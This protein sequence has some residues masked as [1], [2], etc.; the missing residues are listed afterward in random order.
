MRTAYIE[1]LSL[2]A[3][4]SKDICCLI[5]D[6]GAIVYDDFRHR[7]PSQYLN[8]GISEAAMIGVAAGMSSCGHIPFV[9][10]ICPFL[11]MRAYEQ[12]RNDLCLQKMNVKMVGIGAGFVYSNLGPTHHGIED[13]AVLRVLPDMTI[14]SPADE[15]E[16]KAAVRAA[17]ETKGPVYIRLGRNK[18]PQIHKDMDFG[19]DGMRGLVLREGSDL[20][21][22]ATGLSVYYALQAAER[23]AQ[24]GISVAV[25][26]FPVIKP[27]DGEL[28]CRYAHK[29]GFVLSVEQHSITGG[30]GSIICEQLVEN[31]IQ[32]RLHRLGVPDVFVNKYGSYEELLR[33][34]NLDTEGITDAALRLMDKKRD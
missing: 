9:Y 13:F 21:I 1:T 3:S 24:Q 26:D 32:S 25:L 30:L 2:L 4:D 33:Y 14:F 18:V 16:V 12:V 34:Y 28:L 29:T 19:F 31:G 6:N 5:S 22:A 17:V 20:T 27:L 11:V 8:C 23:L 15:Y 7:F 10:T